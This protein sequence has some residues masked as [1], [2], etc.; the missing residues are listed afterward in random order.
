MALGPQGEWALRRRQ[1]VAGYAT[2]A[3][4]GLVLV[5]PVNDYSGRSQQEVLNHYRAS[6]HSNALAVADKVE[7]SIRSIYENL[8]TL[9]LLPST[10]SIARHGENLSDEARLTF[11]QVYN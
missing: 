10:R 2:I 1:V 9:S 8:R 3:L 4:I 7:A 5:I 11:Q 6:Q